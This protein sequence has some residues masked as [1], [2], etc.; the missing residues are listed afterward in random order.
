MTLPLFKLI[1]FTLI[2]G[3]KVVSS[4]YVTLIEDYLSVINRNNTYNSFFLLSYFLSICFLRPQ[5]YEA[6]AIIFVQSA[7]YC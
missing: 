1:F 3:D 6:I 4:V 5:D 2:E 7:S